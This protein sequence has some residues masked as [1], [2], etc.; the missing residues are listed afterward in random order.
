MQA[1]GIELLAAVDWRIG[2]PFAPNAASPADAAVVLARCIAAQLSAIKRKK[3]ALPD[4]YAICSSISSPLFDRDPAPAECFFDEVER[5]A[6]V[7]PLGFIRAYECSIWGFALRFFCQQTDARRVLLTLVDVELQNWAHFAA[8]PLWGR[9]GFGVTTLLF[10][11]P[12]SRNVSLVTG[13]I[14]PGRVFIE[15][16]R[17]IKRHRRDGQRNWTFLPF[18]RG[19]M[20]RLIERAIGTDKLAPD[21]WEEYGHCFES[22]PWIGIMRWLDNTRPL[23]S[24]TVTAG[25]LSYSGYYTVCDVVLSA[26]TAIELRSL[27]GDDDALALALE[28]SGHS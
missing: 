15:F 2:F 5:M 6:G 4:D 11:V 14:D 23:E 26:D 13:S 16:A 12:P 17:A 21:R 28:A 25:S 19:D 8:M 7:R 22:D 24:Q 20:R 27:A 18:L 3:G 10:E 1:E 9:S